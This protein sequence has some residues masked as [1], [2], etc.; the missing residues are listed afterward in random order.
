[1]KL[2]PIIKYASS[3]IPPVEEVSNCKVFL[4]SWINMPDTGPYAKA[5][6]SASRSDKSI[7]ANDGDSGTGNS[8]KA[9]TK[10]MAES[11]GGH[12]EHAHI[13]SG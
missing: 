5:P 3:P 1:M 11:A 8:K 2:L 7:R 13:L 12:C 9:S 6:I 4:I 10:A